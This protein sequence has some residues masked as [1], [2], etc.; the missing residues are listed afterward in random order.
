MQRETD[1]PL[2]LVVPAHPSATAQH[3]PADRRNGTFASLSHSQSFTPSTLSFTP[4]QLEE[5]QS[6]SWPAAQ[7]MNIGNGS[8]SFTDQLLCSPTLVFDNQPAFSKVLM[9]SYL[10]FLLTTALAFDD[11][12]PW[13][14]ETDQTVSDSILAIPGPHPVTVSFLTRILN[15]H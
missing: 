8:Q 1:S 13:E 10:S 11:D 9:T 7:P 4:A 3:L 14:E 15:Q 5:F 2:Q 6:I 12:P